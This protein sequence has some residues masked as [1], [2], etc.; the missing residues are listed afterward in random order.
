[1]AEIDEDVLAFNNMGDGRI[2]EHLPTD[3]KA[4]VYIDD[5]AAYSTDFYILAQNEAGYWVGE[6]GGCSCYTSTSV[7]GPFATIEKAL[8]RLSEG[9]RDYVIRALKRAGLEP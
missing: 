1:M 7:D 9:R 5:S 8:F 2:D 6:A 3:C 4:I